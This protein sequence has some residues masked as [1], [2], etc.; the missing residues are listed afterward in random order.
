[1]YYVKTCCVN[2]VLVRL[3]NEKLYYIIYIYI[4]V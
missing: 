2:Y 1:M 4:Y 3:N